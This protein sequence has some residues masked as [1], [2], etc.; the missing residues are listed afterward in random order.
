MF[1]NNL[2]TTNIESVEEKSTLDTNYCSYVNDIYLNDA[3]S[4]ERRVNL[5][6]QDIWLK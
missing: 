3:L 5:Q 4:F 2:C 6:F 1:T